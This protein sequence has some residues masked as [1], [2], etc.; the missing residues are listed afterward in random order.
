MPSGII[1]K[2]RQN[3][4]QNTTTNINYVQN[5]VHLKKP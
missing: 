2:A 1:K 4:N 3:Q 5:Y